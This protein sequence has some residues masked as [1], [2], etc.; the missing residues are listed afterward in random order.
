MSKTKAPLVLKATHITLA[1]EFAGTE[2]EGAEIVCDGRLSLGQLMP[3]ARLLESGVQF[4]DAEAVL[5]QFGEG[6]LVEWNLE[7]ETGVLPANG[8]GFLNL[9][10]PMCLLIIKAWIQ[11]LTAV[12]APLAVPSRNGS[13]SE[14]LTTATAG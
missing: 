8:D 10:L 13:S 14:E 6:V 7:E 2:L 12:P 11:R 4:E 9:S 5:R 3:F 1:E